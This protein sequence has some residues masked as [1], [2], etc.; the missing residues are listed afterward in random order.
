VSRLPP[1]HLAEPLVRNTLDSTLPMQNPFSTLSMKRFLLLLPL[2]ACTIFSSCRDC[3]NLVCEYAFCTNG[4]CVPWRD[5]FVGT[6]SGATICEGDTVGYGSSITA[7]TLNSELIIDSLLNATMVSGTTFE[8]PSQ[9]VSFQGNT[10]TISGSGSVN[11]GNLLMYTTI[12]Q[13]GTTTTC[14]F[15]GSLDAI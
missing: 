15:R 1:E 13:G 4:Q 8:I 9:P 10:V 2:I 11:A 14:V 3:S 5:D 6:Y 12:E 7:G